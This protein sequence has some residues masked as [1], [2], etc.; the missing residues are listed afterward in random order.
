MFSAWAYSN[1]FQQNG[2][3]VSKQLVGNLEWSIFLNSGALRFTPWKP[4]VDFS[5]AIQFG[6][7]FPLN[8]WHLVTVFHDATANKVGMAMDNDAFTTGDTGGPLETPGNANFR[9]AGTD[10]GT[11]DQFTL[12][13]RLD[14]ALWMKPAGD[15]FGGFAEEI[16]SWLWNNGNGR[17][18]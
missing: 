8:S 13:G 15:L 2:Y 10:F 14:S 12:N 11:P 6:D 3:I 4:G 17:Q 1:V 16:K 9:L 5:A 7:L 18:I